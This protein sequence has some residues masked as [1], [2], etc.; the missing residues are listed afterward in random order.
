MLT[1]S[2]LANDGMTS[3]AF[4]HDS[5][6]THMGEATDKLARVLREQFVTM[7]KGNVLENFVEQLREQIPM[8]LAEKLPPLPSVGTL[9]LA[10]ILDSRY[11]FA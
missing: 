3:F 10:A 9:D 6:G 2:S 11:F 7:Y 1:A 5:Y 8:E 4:I